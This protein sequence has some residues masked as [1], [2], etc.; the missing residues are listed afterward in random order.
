MVPPLLQPIGH[1][2][3]QW[4]LT[5]PPPPPPRARPARRSPALTGPCSLSAPALLASGCCS[6]GQQGQKPAVYVSPTGL[7]NQQLL[8]WYKQHQAPPKKKKKA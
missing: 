7:T 3:T 2:D 5:R 4:P 8:N 1:R 6:G